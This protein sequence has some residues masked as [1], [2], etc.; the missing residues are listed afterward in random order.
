MK[1]YSLF[2]AGGCLLAIGILLYAI[3]PRTTKVNAGISIP[4]GATLP[5]QT[6][7]NYRQSANACGPYSAAAVLRVLTRQDIS[8]EDISHTTPWRYHGYTLPF[9][10]TQTLRS[11]GIIAHEFIITGS[12]EEKLAWLR[13]QIAQTKPVILL[14][15]K[16]GLLHYVTILGY[17]DDQFHLY[18]SL[19]EKG[20]RNL[21]LDLNSELPGNETW[22][23]QALLSFWQKGGVAG[24]Y[25]Y[26]AIIAQDRSSANPL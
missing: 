7:W 23:S 16:E 9:G 26:L 3:Y 18:D 25:Q 10:I 17:Q 14:G 22:T 19:E 5:Y 8:S 24:L 20:E 15:R 4:S 6:T 12:G 11:H 2:I 13:S 1:K 21:T